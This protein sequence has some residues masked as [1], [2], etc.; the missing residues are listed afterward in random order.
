MFAGRIIE[1]PATRDDRRPVLRV[2]IIQAHVCASD[3][4]RIVI[5]GIRIDSTG[6]EFEVR[7]LLLT[8]KQLGRYLKPQPSSR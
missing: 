7:T 5:R 6:R 1:I 8:L 3:T 2:R 4:D